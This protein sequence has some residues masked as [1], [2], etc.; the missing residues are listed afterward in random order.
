MN[1]TEVMNAF[2][3]GMPLRPGSEIVIGDLEYGAIQNLARFRAER[4]GLKLRTIH[5]PT[6]PEE[7]A[8]V[9]AESL[10][11]G[12]LEQLSPETSLLIL[13]DVM[14]SNGLT[15]PLPELARETRKRGVLLAIDGAHGP[16]FLPVDLGRLDDVDFY[17]G[18][19]HKWMLG[20]KGTAFGWLPERHQTVIRPLHAGWTTF[21]TGPFFTEFGGGSRFQGAFLLNG[22]HDFAPYFA[23]VDTIDF[24]DRL[25]REKIRDRI[26]AL[27]TVVEDEMRR[28]LPDWKLASPPLGP[29]RGPLVA[30]TLP[31]RLAGREP[32][33]MREMIE[34]HHVQVHIVPVQKT[35][36]LR[37]SPHI[38]LSEDEITR[39]VKALASL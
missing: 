11:S 13:S 30:Y 12:I 34:R 8:G 26:V 36:R 6:T 5:L 18:N 33:L 39:G 35:W 38:Y 10:V 17:G 9:T 1:V 15:L 20:A 29:R 21:E 14:T 3:L 23:I 16:G 25:G 2:V 22:C 4:D 7:I 24:W 31:A 28:Q 27:Q 19:L 32:Q 37:L